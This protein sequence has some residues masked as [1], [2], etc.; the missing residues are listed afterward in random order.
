METTTNLLV[1]TT[2]LAFTAD[3]TRLAA[4]V[5]TLYRV[6]AVARDVAAFVTVVA[7]HILTALGLGWAVAGK[8]AT[9]VA[10]IAHRLIWG[11]T[12]VTGNVTGLCKYKRRAIIRID[13]NLSNILY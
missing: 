2:V 6:R 9:L 4:H 8:V 3:V 13:F 7:R 12:A 11:Q 1:A 5:A 10:H